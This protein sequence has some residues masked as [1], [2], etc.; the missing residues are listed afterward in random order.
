MLLSNYALVYS[1][2]V[3]VPVDESIPEDDTADTT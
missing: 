1:D 3:D 2:D